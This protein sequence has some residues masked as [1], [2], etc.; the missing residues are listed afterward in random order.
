MHNLL[1]TMRERHKAKQ[2]KGFQLSGLNNNHK[3]FFLSHKNPIEEIVD[4]SSSMEK[5]NGM[6]IKN[7][8]DKS[9][10]KTETKIWKMN[11]NSFPKNP[12]L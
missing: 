10:G 3:Q 2:F 9:L 1:N 7:R 11:Q 6:E 4:F 8:K 5:T 12:F